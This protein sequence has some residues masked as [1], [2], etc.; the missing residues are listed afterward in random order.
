MS[1]YITVVLLHTLGCT[2]RCF[3][4]QINDVR[5]HRSTVGIAVIF[6]IMIFGVDEY[7]NTL[8]PFGIH[9]LV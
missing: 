4:E 3:V 1:K 8:A 2:T 5:N 6:V 7:P 9:A